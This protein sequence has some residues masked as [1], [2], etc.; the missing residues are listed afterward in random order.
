MA[1]FHGQSQSNVPGG[2]FLYGKFTGT[3][4]PTAPTVYSGLGIQSISHLNTGRY[5][6]TLSE[7]VE[8]GSVFSVDAAVINTLGVA[9][10]LL[11]TMHVDTTGTTP[12]IEVQVRDSTG[13]LT[14]GSGS[15]VTFCVGCSNS[16]GSF[17]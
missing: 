7:P 4:A 2:H 9:S 6:I 1:S 10:P 14:A 16:L 5:L 13:A 17:I 15:V 12:V 11:A 3:T 8:L